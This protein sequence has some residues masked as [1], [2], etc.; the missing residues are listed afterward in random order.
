MNLTVDL[1][2]TVT[3]CG[4]TPEPVSEFG[5]GEPKLDKATGKPIYV[6]AVVWITETD[7]EVIKVRTPGAPQGLTMGAPVVLTN[8][9]A[10]PWTMAERSGVSFRADSVSAVERD[11]S[12]PTRPTS[13]GGDQ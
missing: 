5:S 8:L 2:N 1:K 9:V 6:V 4:G 11:R 13:A 10:S 12:V 3:L 7:T